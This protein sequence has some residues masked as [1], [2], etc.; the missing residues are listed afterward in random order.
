MRA[1]LCDACVPEPVVNALSS[2]KIPAISVNRIPETAE[3]DSKVVDVA[4]TL[5]AII[6]TLDRDFT[7]EQ[8]LFAAMLEKGSRVVRLRPSKC[9]PNKV[10]EY[11]ATM[12]INNYREWQ[13]LFKDGSGIISCTANGNRFRKLEDFPWYSEEK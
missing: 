2:L 12:I 5:D 6:V 3:A 10:I 11:I 4:H 13:E 8:P 7:T 9:D 1:L